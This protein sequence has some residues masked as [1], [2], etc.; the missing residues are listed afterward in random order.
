MFERWIWRIL[1]NRM[2]CKCIIKGIC[3]L[4]LRVMLSIFW[5]LTLIRYE[6]S[7]RQGCI[8]IN[9]IKQNF[10]QGC[11]NSVEYGEYCTQ[12]VICGIVYH[13]H[14]IPE[15]EP[16]MYDSSAR[17]Q[18]KCYG[19]GYH[20]MVRFRMTFSS[21]RITGRTTLFVNEHVCLPE[22]I[23]ELCSKPY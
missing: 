11:E 7:E 20:N 23:P 5:K 21:M 12:C 1:R 15:G 16:P 19:C 3:K 6:F 9:L 2:W 22:K 10:G 17:L 14:C 4:L 18:W 13:Y 8:D